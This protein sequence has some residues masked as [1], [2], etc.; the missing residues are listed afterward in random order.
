MKVI[1]LKDVPGTGKKSDIKEVADGYARNFLLK[2]GLAKPA[3]D[4]VMN[5]LQQETKKK[6]KQMERDL[7]EEQ[8]KAAKLDGAELEI[9]AKVNSNGTLYAALSTNK[10]A[11]N[12]KEKL[13]VT[14]KPRQ[15]DLPSPIKD[16]GEHEAKVTLSHGLEA[17]LSIIINEA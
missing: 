3:S 1:L 17:S 5:R 15:I 8:K 6:V 12:I 14:I 10:I 11:Q 2:K 13:G 7:K 4:H 9:D 16:L